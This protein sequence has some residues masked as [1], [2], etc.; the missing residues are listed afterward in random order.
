MK[1]KACA[2]VLVLLSAMLVLGACSGGGFSEKSEQ[3]LLELCNEA[4]KDGG[5]TLLGIS[6]E[7]SKSASIRADE[8]AKED[9][10]SHI[11][12]DGSGCFTVITSEYVYAGENLAKGNNP[13]NVFEKW[14]ES[15]E[16]RENIENGSYTKTGFG[17]AE[18][19]GVYYWV[20][21]FT[22]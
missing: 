22:D 11:R 16:H 7:L 18:K 17:C 21:L 12:P 8:I 9:N 2:L 4:R 19:D 14:M 10:L 1:I 15:P 6:D 3:K 20:Q 13:E 5:L